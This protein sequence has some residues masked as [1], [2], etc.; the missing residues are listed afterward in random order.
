MNTRSNEKNLLKKF[1]C[2]RNPFFS[3]FLNYLNIEKFFFRINYISSTILP[4]PLQVYG[5]I[6]KNNNNKITTIWSWI[7][8]F[9][10]H[11]CQIFT[12]NSIV[13]FFGSSSSCWCFCCCYWKCLGD[14]C[15]YMDSNHRQRN[16]FCCMLR[17]CYLQIVTPFFTISFIG[18]A[19][20]ITCSIVGT[21]ILNNSKAKKK[22][23]WA[24]FHQFKDIYFASK[25]FFFFKYFVLFVI[26]ITWFRSVKKKVFDFI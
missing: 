10:C 15:A 14:V 21:Q 12:E 19:L 26:V 20:S 22:E 3:F 7:R 17:C 18:D 2:I 6:G 9:L 1:P 13:F 24:S 11:R 5:N 4:A 16:Y 25:Q 23:S 8:Y